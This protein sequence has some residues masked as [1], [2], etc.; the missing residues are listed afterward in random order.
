MV[1]YLLVIQRELDLGNSVG[2]VGNLRL[3]GDGIGEPIRSVGIQPLEEIGR[4]WEQGFL[5]QARRR[6]PI[7]RVTGT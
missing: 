6:A 2:I 7:R 5:A 1:A 4:P 3:A